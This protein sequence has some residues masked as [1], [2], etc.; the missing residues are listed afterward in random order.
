[1]TN[2][3]CNL[4]VGMEFR[5]YRYICSF[6]NEERKDGNTRSAQIKEWKRYFD[7]NKQGKVWTITKVYSEPLPKLDKRTVNSGSFCEREVSKQF[8]I[9]RINWKSPMIYKIQLESDVYIGSTVQPRQRFFQ[10]LNNSDNN[11][12]K[13]SKLINNGATFECL[14]LFNGSDKELREREFE[15]IRDYV[16]EGVYNVINE[17]IADVEKNKLIQKENNELKLN[18]AK[19]FM[20]TVYD[21]E[22]G[23]L[24]KEFECELDGNRNVSVG[25]TCK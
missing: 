24:L 18:N 17:R 9:P 3:Y 14:E 15:I 16:N 12:D 23:E 13:T 2:K 8:M 5:G 7:Y 20:I 25:V 6:L 1:M 11:H 19:N 22:T 10:H 4:E 21:T